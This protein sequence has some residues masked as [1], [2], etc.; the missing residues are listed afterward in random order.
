MKLLK[1]S[2]EWCSPCK[3][4]QK[5]IDNAGDKIPVEIE[6]IDL[7]EDSKTAMKYNVRGVPTLILV[8]DTGN[9]IKRNV[10]MMTE[11]K[12]LEWLK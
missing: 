11:D 5:V 6:N 9:E 12:L 3:Q 10:G 2:A 1:V 4:L 7:D 8:D